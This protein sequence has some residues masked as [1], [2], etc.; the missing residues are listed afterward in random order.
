MHPWGLIYIQQNSLLVCTTIC[1][2]KFIQ[3]CNYHLDWDMQYFHHPKFF[4]CQLAINPPIIAKPSNH[5][6]DFC[7]YNFP[8]PKK[9]LTMQCVD[10][11]SNLFH[12]GCFWYF[13]LLLLMVVIIIIYF[14]VVI[15][16]H[17]LWYFLK[18]QYQI[19]NYLRCFQ[20]RIIVNKVVTNIHLQAFKMWKCFPFS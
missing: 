19:D 4:L 10:F 15:S 14:W 3:W 13:A 5:W 9:S 18:T 17:G 8:S 16:M 1:F 2:G 20:S 11:L 12:L 6:P 7:P